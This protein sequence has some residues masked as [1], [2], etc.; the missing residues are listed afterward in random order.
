VLNSILKVVC[1]VYSLKHT[2]MKYLTYLISKLALSLFTLLL[3]FSCSEEKITNDAIVH[4]PLE[5]PE[6][7][8]PAGNPDGN[9]PIPFE[10]GLENVTNPDTVVGNGAPES[11]TCDAVVQAVA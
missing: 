7:G 8:P 9:A 2:P 5:N 6:D 1:F 4:N 10:A 11:C 3:L